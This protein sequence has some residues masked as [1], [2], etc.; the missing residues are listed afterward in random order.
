MKGRFETGL[1]LLNMLLP[2]LLFFKRGLTT[3]V[4][5][6]FGN[7]PE[8]SEEFTTSKQFN[9]LLKKEVG[10]SSRARFKVLYGFFQILPLISSKSDIDNDFLRMWSDLSYLTPV[11]P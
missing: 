9:T 1:Y 11:L 10:I 7:V 6:D 4:F 2:R 5:R 8:R 3:A